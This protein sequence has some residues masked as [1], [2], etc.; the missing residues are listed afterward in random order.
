[1]HNV[2]KIISEWKKRPKK[3]G[4]SSG[5]KMVEAIV[6]TEFGLETKHIAVKR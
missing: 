3:Y 2:V 4:L 1:M 6:K 5:M